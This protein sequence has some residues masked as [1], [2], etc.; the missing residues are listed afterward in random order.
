ML[1]FVTSTFGS[2]AD[3]GSFVVGTVLLTRKLSALSHAPSHETLDE[4]IVNDDGSIERRNEMDTLHR[5]LGFGDDP[6]KAFQV[7]NLCVLHHAHA[8]TW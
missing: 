2:Y 6:D 8:R 1:V 3:C 7:E 4:L 5:S